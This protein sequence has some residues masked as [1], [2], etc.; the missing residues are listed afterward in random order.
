[1]YIEPSESTQM[2][3]GP[4][5]MPGSLPRLVRWSRLATAPQTRVVVNGADRA[6]LPG[7]KQDD[8]EI[9]VGEDGLTISG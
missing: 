9:E 2:P 7:P 1:M 4:Q 6:E 8:V 5:N 3:C